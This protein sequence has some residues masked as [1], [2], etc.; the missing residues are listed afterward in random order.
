MKIAI[1]SDIHANLEALQAVLAFLKDA[2]IDRYICLGDIVGYGA[3][4]NECTEEVRKLNCP[5]VIGNHDYVGVGMGDISYFNMTAKTAILWT[6]NQLKAEN[7]DFLKAL[8]FTHKENSFLAVHASPQSPEKW[9]YVIT[10]D[11]A[12]NNMNHF[13]EQ[14][15]FIG[16]SHIPFFLELDPEGNGELNRNNPLEIKDGYRYLINVGSVGQPRDNNPKSAFVIYDTDEKMVTLKRLAYDVGKA[17]EKIIEA[18]LPVQLA[19]RL[20]SGY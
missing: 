10:M 19:Q 4:P 15:C 16:H 2:S 20:Q 8:P 11:S 7:A 9:E 18:G 6:R 5:V 14:I 13:S 3:S 17:Q 12:L 1:F